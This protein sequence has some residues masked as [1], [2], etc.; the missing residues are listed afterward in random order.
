MESGIPEE[1]GAGMTSVLIDFLCEFNA[2]NRDIAKKVRDGWT[3]EAL[4]RAA[5]ERR[6]SL[7]NLHMALSRYPFPYTVDITYQNYWQGQ[8]EFE[9][10]ETGE[11]VGTADLTRAEMDMLVCA[12]QKVLGRPVVGLLTEQARAAML[13]SRNWVHADLDDCHPEIK[14]LFNMY[15]DSTIGPEQIW[16]DT[17]DFGRQYIINLVDMLNGV[18]LNFK[19]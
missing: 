16:E 4:Y 13:I 2:G 11:V 17:T 1:Q 14:A 9:H 15:L 6:A 8:Y 18:N 10:R 5:D 12:A 7:G 3:D 19:E